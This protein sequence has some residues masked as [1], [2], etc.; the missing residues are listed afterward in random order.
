MTM[1]ALLSVSLLY[2]L[3]FPPCCFAWTEG[4]W[5]GI[6][7]AVS[8]TAV[9]RQDTAPSSDV[10]DNCGGTGRLGDGTVSVECPVCDGTGKPVSPGAHLSGTIESKHTPPGMDAPTVEHDAIPR[11]GGSYKKRFF[12]SN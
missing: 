5:V 6:V 7:E 9:L 12:R 10:C 1:K 2:L 11:S 3:C 4:E 8:G